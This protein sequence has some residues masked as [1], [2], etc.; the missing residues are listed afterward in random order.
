MTPDEQL[1]ELR[2]LIAASPKP[3]QVYEGFRQWLRK[4]SAENPTA[5][6]SI[7]LLHAAVEQV[8]AW[9]AGLYATPRSLVSFIAKLVGAGSGGKVLDPACGLG[10]L[11]RETAKARGAEIVHGVEL[12]QECC[13]IAREVLGAEANLLQADVLRSS[14]ELETSYDL[15]VADL[16]LGMKIS[17]PLKLPNWE[18]D[19][20]GEFGH[21]VAVWA[22]DRLSERGSALLTLSAGFIW[23]PSGR[24]AQEAIRRAGCRV[25]AL[26]HLP[27]GTYPYT[28]TSAYLVV[29]DRGEQETVFVGQFAHSPEHQNNLISNCLRRQPGPQP[30]LGRLCALEEFMGFD[31]LAAS[32]RLKRLVR[33]PGW[34]KYAAST[35]IQ[36]TVR[37]KALDEV[38]PGSLNALYLRTAGQVR[39]ARDLDALSASGSKD[40]VRLNLD[41]QYADARYMVHWFNET[42]V[43][44][45][46]VAAL[47]SSSTVPRLDADGLLGGSLYLPDV[48]AQRQTLAGLEHLE[49]VRAEAAELERAL[50]SQSEKPATVVEKIRT[51]NQEDRYEDWIES[52]PFPLASI[53]W[54]HRACGGS[55]KERLEILLHF[56]E[57][58]A[59]FMATVHLSAFMAEAHL[60]RET[61]PKLTTALASHNLSLE[62][63]SFGAWKQT[64]E[65]LS[66]R[67]RELTAD[68][69]GKQ[70]VAKMYSAPSQHH[71]EMLCD[72]ALV[73]TLQRANSIRNDSKGHGGAMGEEEA[74]SI[75]GDLFSQVNKVREAF[76]RSWLEYEL[77]QPA[78]SKFRGGVHHYKAKRLVGTRSSPFEVVERVSAE[79]MESDRLY[80]FDVLGRRGLLLRPFIQVVASPEKKANACYIFSRSE[81]E[82]SRFVS[83]HFEQ[84]SSLLAPFPDLDETFRRLRLVDA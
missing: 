18:G 28:N 50:L 54:R 38:E 75:H 9:Q 14:I 82:G 56:F 83:Y 77:I 27:R 41:P 1:A 15:I 23:S 33:Q 7:D 58:T 4:H 70:L 24:R 49:R 11:L 22:C 60:W 59:A 46:T 29:L 2:Q 68:A 17:D 40:I 36:S 84:E 25:R 30:A 67:C 66:A 62:R 35:V 57:A 39:A 26:I 79:P 43:G 48:E 16:P 64:V 71:V 52:L 69:E 80:L 3:A 78:E 34:T 76:G 63:A 74:K 51:L 65:L 19:Y 42:N 10:L 21:A 47:S 8:P 20:R 72:P 73:S 61:A 31:A 13:E 5:A 32:E 53:L 44:Q 6:L 37:G 81:R 12:S 55:N 45:E